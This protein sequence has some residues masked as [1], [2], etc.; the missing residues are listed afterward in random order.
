MILLSKIEEAKE[1]K[2]TKEYL[3]DEISKTMY[4]NDLKERIRQY[5]EEELEK[6][7]SKKEEVIPE[8]KKEEKKEENKT[9][10]KKA[11]SRKKPEPKK[12]THQTRRTSRYNSKIKK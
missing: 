10:K 7:Q 2:I 8:V 12:V 4:I 3:E 9:T 5:E 11:A 1:H 6:K